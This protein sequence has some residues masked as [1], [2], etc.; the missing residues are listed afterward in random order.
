MLGLS[1]LSSLLVQACAKLN[2][3]IRSLDPDLHLM[4]MSSCSRVIH[5]S[6]MKFACS[7]ILLAF[8]LC[9]CSACFVV[10]GRVSVGFLPP[11][12]AW[13]YMQCEVLSCWR[14]AAAR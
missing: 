3:I 11:P 9:K 4:S 6:Y 10:L 2:N 7:L 12:K 5:D 13:N 14:S 1:V 8:L